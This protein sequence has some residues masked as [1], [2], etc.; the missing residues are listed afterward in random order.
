MA[1]FNISWVKYLQ[2]LHHQCHHLLLHGSPG[3][4]FGLELG[5]LGRQSLAA[6]VG[7][8]HIGMDPVASA[9]GRIVISNA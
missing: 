8:H 2:F 9:N 4:G 7:Q 1:R 6:Q 3:P 5:D